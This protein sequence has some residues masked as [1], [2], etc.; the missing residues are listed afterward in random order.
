MVRVVTGWKNE[1]LHVPACI[2]YFLGILVGGSSK[3]LHLH[4]WQSGILSSS[5]T[6]QFHMYEGDTLESPL[7]C[8]CMSM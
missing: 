1:G 8:V 6:R 3:S 2:C 5:G 4:S 7:K